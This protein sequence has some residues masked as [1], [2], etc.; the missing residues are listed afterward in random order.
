VLQQAGA[1]A[2]GRLWC[3]ARQR[4]LQQRRRQG[5]GGGAPGTQLTGPATVM[6]V[7][8][9]WAVALSCVQVGALGLPCSSSAP[10]RTAMT[11]A[12]YSGSSRLSGAPCR[13]MV[14]R[15]GK[16]ASAVPAVRLPPLSKM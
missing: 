3:C 8:P 5:G 13:V 16:G 1:Q 4:I 6:L 11:L 14:A 7:S 12:P 9:G 2:S 15:P 10:S